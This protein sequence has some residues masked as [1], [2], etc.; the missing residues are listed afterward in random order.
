[1]RWKAPKHLTCYDIDV[2]RISPLGNGTLRS[3]H[4]SK[5]AGAIEKQVIVA[6]E[7]CWKQADASAQ[8]QIGDTFCNGRDVPGPAHPGN[9]GSDR[10]R[11]CH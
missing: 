8:V 5:E 7:V 3:Q 11:Y 1:M 4:T 9:F 2:L 10:L 6:S